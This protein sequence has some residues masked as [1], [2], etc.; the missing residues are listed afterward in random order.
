LREARDV[1]AARRADL[2]EAERVARVAESAAEAAWQ[3]AQAAEAVNPTTPAPNPNPW[4]EAHHEHSHPPRR[5]LRGR[6]SVA[7]RPTGSVPRSS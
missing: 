7:L 3:E 1:V 2:S 4:K 6:V 5:C